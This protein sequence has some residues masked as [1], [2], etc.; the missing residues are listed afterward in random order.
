MTSNTG[1]QISAIHILHNTSRGKT[2]Q[3]MKLGQL[4]K[5]NV[6]KIFLFKNHTTNEVG[7]LVPDLFSVF[8]SSFI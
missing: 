1:Q 4:I 3:V 7:R 2:N 8:K 5:H 6:R